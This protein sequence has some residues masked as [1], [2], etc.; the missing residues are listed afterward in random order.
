[1]EENKANQNQIH[2]QNIQ[3]PPLKGITQTQPTLPKKKFPIKIIIVAIVLILLVLIGTSGFI[4]KDQIMNLVAPP[5]PTPTTT[6]SPTLA[7]KPDWKTFENDELSFQYPKELIS[8]HCT[9][10]YPPNTIGLHLKTDFERGSIGCGIG[11][12]GPGIFFTVMGEGETLEKALNIPLGNGDEL[13]DVEEL[14]LPNLNVKYVT[15]TGN[16]SLSDRFYMFQ[17]PKT[18]K[19]YTISAKPQDKFYIDQIIPILSTLKFNEDQSINTSSWK[20]YSYVDLGYS[21]RAPIGYEASVLDLDKG[22]NSLQTIS[23]NK[24]KNMPDPDG[25]T[26]SVMP[27][28][29]IK[30]DDK[31][32][33]QFGINNAKSAGIT[34]INN[35]EW[36][37]YNITQ[38]IILLDHFENNKL[39]TIYSMNGSEL[40]D[41]II[42]TFKFTE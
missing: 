34:E 38:V 36:H 7:L 15:R 42:P 6:P 12:K 18:K 41:K 8:F 20:S 19:V 2:Q 30:D 16:N 21:F 14:S 25:I 35:K 37:E 27:A 33:A 39:Y 24:V 26:I 5:T 11:L 4:F 10:G 17:N 22:D 23:I 1:M 3:G 29:S 40:I 32:L 28:S 9:S 31:L 13:S